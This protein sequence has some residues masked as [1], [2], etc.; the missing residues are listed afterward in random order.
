MVY[1]K[2]DRSG[3][4]EEEEV[5]QGASAVIAV[6]AVG[7]SRGNFFVSLAECALYHAGPARAIGA[8][9]AEDGRVEGTI[10]HGV[11]TFEE[12]FAREAVGLGWRLLIHP[13]TVL[14]GVDAGAGDEDEAPE[15][16]LRREGREEVAGT[17]K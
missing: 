5:A 3:L 12:A 4:F 17:S 9:E 15:V 2:V 7:V 13:L 11:L 8:S 16:H 14:L 1:A 6:D 10:E